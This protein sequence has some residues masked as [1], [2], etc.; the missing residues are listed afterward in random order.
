MARIRSI[1]PEF[2]DDRKLAKR[3]SRDAR[4]LYIA[5]WNLADEHGRLN[6]DPQWIKGQVFS[7]EHDID[8]AVVAKL[9]DE[10]AVPELRRIVQ[11]E[12]DGD[13][14]IYLPYLAKHQRLEPE[15]VKSR[16]PDPPS[17]S[18]ADSSERRADEPARDADQPET[19]TEPPG[20]DADSPALL[21]GA[22]SREQVAGSRETREARTLPGTALLD[23]YLANTSPR[24]PKDDTRKLGEAIDR[25]VADK[26]PVD[27]IAEAL[28]RY[29]DRDKARYGLGILTSLVT[30]IVKERA[31][32]SRASPNGRGASKKTNYSDKDYAGGW[33]STAR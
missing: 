11:Y 3:T 20:S 29:R 26:T 12:A 6:G 28:E 16:L 5:L 10:L 30:D 4:L 15:K 8:A 27:V 7:Y 21:Y 9:L 24:P 25:L 32:T 2:W 33:N 13:P 14:Y 22:G 31:A 18:Y 1:K 17:E 23:D 19:G